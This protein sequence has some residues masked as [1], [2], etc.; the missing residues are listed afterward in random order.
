[1]TN[2]YEAVIGLEVHVELN[3]K[4]KIFCS[5]KT[6][7]GAEPN[8][9]CCPVCMGMPGTLPVLNKKAVEYAVRAGIA[10]EC[11]ISL[12]S[13]FD[14]K[15]YFYP[16]L[17]KGYQITQYE[18]PICKNGR[19]NVEVNGVTRKIGITRIHLE[20]D[21]GK[22][23]HDE[24]KGT[25]IDCNRCGVPLIEIV[26]EPDIR[27]ADE[28]EA[29]L[30][31]LRSL[32]MYSGISD[33]R[34][35]EG[36]F[37]C[38]VNIS[39]R[40]KG[41]KDFGTRS[42]IKNLNSFAFTAKAIEYEKERQIHLLES[43]GKVERE[44]RRFDPSSG[45][46]FTMRKKE[47]ETDYRF[48]PE[49]DLPPVLLTEEDVDRIKAEMPLLLRERLAL[50]TG[51]Y[52]LPDAD[53]EILLSNVSLADFFEECAKLSKSPRTSANIIISDILS[54]CK[55]GTFSTKIPPRSL[56]SLSDMFFDEQINSSTQKKLTKR[57]WEDGID[58]CVTVIKEDLLQINDENIIRA[59]VR[60]AIEENPKCVEDY[61][62]G[63]RAAAKTVIGKAM[64]KSRGKAN[65][66]IL[67]R[68]A[69]EMLDAK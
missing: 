42:E 23:I 31:T 50:Y 28:A 2:E 61:R 21:A 58:P 13:A 59:L 33:C 64:A 47:S 8:S 35:N 46:T 24:E 17:P 4:T 1:M 29:Y 49:P 10:T 36:S 27:S 53:A 9:Q 18:H 3:T 39:V 54:Y 7:F 65:P 20:E 19:I 45:K 41:E 26:S 5:C 22:L 68:L 34:M 43:G 38:D 16:D 25:L 11:E 69:E 48:F 55:E 63:K 37:R 44:T 66:R 14:R 6:D 60:E 62:R 56:A 52:S 57:M 15:N 67:S 32:I 12:F 51:K 30:R 40:R